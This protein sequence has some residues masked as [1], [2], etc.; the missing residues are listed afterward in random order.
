MLGAQQS[1]AVL[2]DATYGLA[3]NRTG[4]K[5]FASFAIQILWAPMAQAAVNSAPLGI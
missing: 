5:Q 1:S 3:L 4:A 2:P